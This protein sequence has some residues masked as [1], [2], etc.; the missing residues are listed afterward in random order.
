SK[1]EELQ[2]KTSDLKEKKDDMERKLAYTSDQLAGI[3]ELL[4]ELGVS[5]DEIT[6]FVER[7][8]SL[9][10]L[11]FG[12]EEAR[13]VAKELEG[14]GS[15]KE[16]LEKITR[17]VREHGSLEKARNKLKKKVNSLKGSISSLEKRLEKKKAE[18]G[19]IKEKVES[20]EEKVEELETKRD[21]LREEIAELKEEKKSAEEEL[22]RVLKTKKRSEEVAEDLDE[23]ESL[24]ELVSSEED[25]AEELDAEVGSLEERKEKLE[26]SIDKVKESGI[27]QVEA[28]GDEVRRELENLKGDVEKWGEVKEKAGKLENELKYAKYFLDDDILAQMSRPHAKLILDKLVLWCDENDIDMRVKAEETPLDGT[29]GIS[30]YAEPDIADLLEASRKT[31]TGDPV[32]GEPRPDRKAHRADGGGEELPAFKGRKRGISN[33]RSYQLFLSFSKPKSS[34]KSS[35]CFKW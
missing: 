6:G 18:Y 24:E 27:D 32:D 7:Q 28:P 2:E 10:E 35:S 30:P 15:L 5:P 1:I 19:K 17:L 33:L 34:L 3:D 9:D 16:R 11:N 29:R 12:Q 21:E 13:A 22:Q 31:L 8:E 20:R 23:F 26:S 25:R 14:D 4:Q